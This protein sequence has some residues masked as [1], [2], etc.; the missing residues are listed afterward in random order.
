MARIRSVKPEMFT[1][2]TVA[3]LSVP[4]RWTFVGLLTYADDQ[5]RGRDEARLVK[6]AVWPMD[7]D[8]PWQQVA[9]HLDELERA[10]LICRYEAEGKRLLHVSGWPEHQAI[11]HPAKPKLP[12][13]PKASHRN[14][15]DGH[16]QPSGDSPEERGETPLGTGNR[17]REQGKGTGS[18]DSATRVASATAEKPALQLVGPP[19]E[20]AQTVLAAYID[21]RR[22]QGVAGLDRRTKGI[23]ARHLGDAFAGGHPPDVIRLGLADWH[24]SDTHPSVLGSFIDARARGGQPRASPTKAEAERTQM[25]TTYAAGQRWAAQEDD[26][27]ENRVERVGRTHQRELPPPADQA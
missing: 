20:T 25:H 5:G 12:E 4:V 15:P 1:S 16:R 26:R 14:P 2:A 21:W 27:D 22:S 11:S 7:D 24:A 8:M 23:L 6:A 3:A 18:R 13:C 17:E 10:G 19:P 9:A